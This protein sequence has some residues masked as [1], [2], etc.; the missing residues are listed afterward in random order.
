MKP[1]LNV[2][3]AGAGLGGLTA[4]ACLLKRGFRVRIYEQARSLK[5]AG[6]G[7]QTSANAVKVLH[8]LGLRDALA[9]IA[10]L[11]R[12]FLFR[13]FDSG[14]V[15]HRIPL[16][17]QHE[18]TYGA[19][20][21]HSHRAD[22]HDLLAQKVYEL[23]PDC[24]VLDAKVESFDESGDG[25][26]LALA[27][28]RHIKGDVLIGADGIK[29]VIRPRIVGETPIHYT[30]DIAWR[31]TIPAERLPENFMERVTTVW[32]GP[33]KHAVMYYVRDGSILNF[34]GA[35]EREYAEGE[36]WTQKRPW[37][38][39][40]ADYRGWHAD[41]QAVIDAIDKDSCYQWALMDRTPVANWSTDRVTLLGDSAHASLPYMASGANMAIEDGAVLA[42]CFELAGSVPEALQLYQRNRIE[43]TSRIVNESRG[44]RLLYR[45][46][47]EEDMRKA[48]HDSNPSKSRGE[49]LYSYDP[50]TVP[51][52]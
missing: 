35:V 21:F 7:I 34:G 3:I 48:F 51:L 9:E 39:L 29:S 43:R 8:D 30:G 26:T 11:P 4:A 12:A 27:G 6:A 42:R 31:A 23:D 18:K 38:E 16:G 52:T 1:G 22:L 44:M 5:E 33:H 20:Y 32:C 17:E 49:W 15:L 24:I 14:E 36:S 50:L 40:K 41:L 19:P 45:I 2:L 37:E 46:E 13:R 47:D 28:G 10:V 25:V